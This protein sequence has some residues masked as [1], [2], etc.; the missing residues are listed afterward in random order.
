LLPA[1]ISRPLARTPSTS[2]DR[3]PQTR[4]SV[5]ILPEPVERPLARYLLK[6]D[7]HFGRVV[8]DWELQHRTL[9]QQYLYEGDFS[10]GVKELTDEGAVVQDLTTGV[11]GF[12]PEERF[13]F[14]GSKMIPGDTIHG[15][16]CIHLDTTV[17]ESPSTEILRFQTGVVYEWDEAAGEGYII[18]SE[19]QDAS[20]MVR[21]LRR[22]IRWHDSRRLFPGQ[23]VQY[24]LA[25]PEEVPVEA[26]EDKRAP[27]ALH[28]RNIEVQ[29]SLQESFDLL[30]EGS[31]AKDGRKALFHEKKK[32]L[33]AFKQK[34]LQ[35]VEEEK[36]IQAPRNVDEEKL[37]QAPRNVDEEKLIQAPR[38]VDEEKLIQA[39]Q[40]V[41]EEKLIQAGLEAYP[42]MP[43]R[44]EEDKERQP[45]RHPVLQRFAD[46]LPTV[47]EAES[48]VWLWEPDI[49][50]L[51][52]ERYDPIV[53]LQLE[54]PYVPPKPLRI[55][56]HE[57][58]AQRNASLQEEKWHFGIR[59]KLK[60]KPPG[61]R[62]MEQRAVQA[63][64]EHI[65]TSE[66]LR[67]HWKRKDAAKQKV[68]R[69]RSTRPFPAEAK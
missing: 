27:F 62:E 69:L 33:E 3:W 36:L 59:D 61:P 14:Y 4:Q 48:P 13:G 24:E 53:P 49:K 20:Y 32:A 38:N 11:F 57:V 45:R 31:T 66:A 56:T 58:A 34:T 8:P 18:P 17:I 41:D 30:P 44:P 64:W 26:N 40:N 9:E 60:L 7:K 2:T 19:S 68:G 12:V 23:F 1:P 47:A 21:V 6:R 67:R 65:R 55:L 5:E 54:K 28:V 25:L 52:D 50:Y 15:A 42:V 22:D 16:R 51:K 46:E 63:Q 29:F 35:N 10:V 43:R 39:P 37:I